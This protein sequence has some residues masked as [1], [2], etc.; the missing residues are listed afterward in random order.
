M[1]FASASPAFIKACKLHLRNRA[2][3]IRDCLKASFPAWLASSHD[4]NWTRDSSTGKPTAGINS[5]PYGFGA[6]KR[7]VTLTCNSASLLVG[8]L[9]EV[10]SSRFRERR[11]KSRA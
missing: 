10:M 11:S 6:G 1:G 9:G 8:H 7:C 4:P 2:C 5:Q 3:P